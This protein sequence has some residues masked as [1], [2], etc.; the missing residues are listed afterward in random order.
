MTIRPGDDGEYTDT[1]PA[2]AAPTKHP[3]ETQAEGEYTDGDTPDQNPTDT[4]SFTR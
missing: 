1:E 3:D 4:I 2:P